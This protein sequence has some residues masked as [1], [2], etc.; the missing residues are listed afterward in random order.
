[1]E[2]K[3]FR[4]A[5]NLYCTE[6]DVNESQIYHNVGNN[7][8]LPLRLAIVIANNLSPTNYANFI[9]FFTNN[10]PEFERGRAEF[11][12]SQNLQLRQENQALR[13]QLNAD[14]N[15]LN[16]IFNSNSAG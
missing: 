3:Q 12:A 15:K 5:V 1:M 7:L 14:L 2:V 6:F 9:D 13:G 4:A 8:Y 16:R 10:K 11:Y